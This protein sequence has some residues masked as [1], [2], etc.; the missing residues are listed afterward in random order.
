MYPMKTT[1]L[2][3]HEGRKDDGRSAYTA[4]SE[5]GSAVCMVCG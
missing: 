2:H 5:D 4:R 1:G 3:M